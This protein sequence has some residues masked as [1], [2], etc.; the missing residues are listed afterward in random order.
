MFWCH[1]TELALFFTGERMAT[2]AARTLCELM[3]LRK[4]DMDAVKA[5]FP[6]LATSMKAVAEAEKV[7][8]WEHGLLKT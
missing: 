1:L 7:K 3:V 4:A 6:D 8:R 2:V 5:I